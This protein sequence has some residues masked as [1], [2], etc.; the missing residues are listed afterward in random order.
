M[1]RYYNELT[2][3]EMEQVDK[4]E[5]VVM[6]PVGALEQHGNQCP[7]GTDEIIAEGTARR[8]KEALDREIPDYPMLIFPLIP[9]GLSTEH[10]NF[11]GSVTLK[12]DT[13]Y[14][15]LYDICKGLAH[16]VRDLPGV[17]YQ[18]GGLGDGHGNAGDIHLLKDISA[19]QMTGHLSSDS[20]HGDRIHVGCGNT[21]NQ[22]G[23]SGTGGDHAYS[24]LAA[25]PGIAGGHMAGVLLRPHQG[26]ADL[27]MFL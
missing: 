6:I 18:K 11:C 10:V 3:L 25:D 12:P 14:H 22:V 13:F 27:R 19:Q 23:S 5:T 8:I 2:R 4:D 1:V 21:S 26:I 15:V 7:L 9:V 16:H 20:H 17:P 24:Y